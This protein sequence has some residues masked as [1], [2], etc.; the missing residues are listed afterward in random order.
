MYQN[1]QTE[2][3]IE[4]FIFFYTNCYQTLIYISYSI[5]LYIYFIVVYYWSVVTNQYSDRSFI[6]IQYNE[7]IPYNIIIPFLKGPCSTLINELKLILICLSLS[8]FLQGLILHQLQRYSLAEKILRDA[9]Q[10]NSTAHD[11]WNSLGEVLQAQG[12]DA[13]ATEC[14]LTALELEAS[15]PILPFTIIPRALWDTPSAHHQH[16]LC[17]RV[18]H[19]PQH[20]KHTHRNSSSVL[21]CLSHTLRPLYQFS[22]ELWWT[23]I[24]TVISVNFPHCFTLIVFPFLLSVREFPSLLYSS[25]AAHPKTPPPPALPLVSFIPQYKWTNEKPWDNTAVTVKQVIDTAVSSNHGASWNMSRNIQSWDSSSC[26]S[27]EPVITLMQRRSKVC[28]C[29]PCACVLYMCWYPGY[30]FLCGVCACLFSMEYLT[31]CYSGSL[32]HKHT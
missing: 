27:Y 20:L 6:T 18:M 8:V 13:A 10:V 19:E 9:V 15:C 25:G 2:N 14:F 24:D 28:I 4:F 21:Q 11:V 7:I 3:V 17:P 1:Q 23:L 5:I 31:R 16:N 12:N 26:V 29:V 30:P 22:D 32:L